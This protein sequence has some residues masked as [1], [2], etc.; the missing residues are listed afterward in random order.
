MHTSRPA[1]RANS[2]RGRPRAL[3]VQ[4]PAPRL[5]HERDE[6]P[7]REPGTGNATIQ[8]AAADLAAGREDTD[9]YGAARRI[10]RRVAVRQKR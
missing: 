9:C 1:S 4:A 6:S 2:R 10:S 7:D 5:P 8:R 3:A